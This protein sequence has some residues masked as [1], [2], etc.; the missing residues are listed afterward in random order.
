LKDLEE[1]IDK[2]YKPGQY[3]IAPGPEYRTGNELGKN[4]NNKG[5]QYNIEQ[6]AGNVILQANKVPQRSS[7]HA[8]Q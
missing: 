2:P 6:Q 7:Y 4:E 3:K 8:K 5:G 1:N